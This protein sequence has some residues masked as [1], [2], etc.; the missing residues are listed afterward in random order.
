M[1]WE[2]WHKIKTLFKKS[3]AEKKKSLKIKTPPK[4]LLSLAIR[5]IQ[6]NIT[7]RLHLTPVRMAKINR[8]PDNKYQRN[9]GQGEPS[10][11]PNGVETGTAT[12]EIS[13]ASFQKTR[14]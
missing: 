2:N 9:L 3:F 14:H 13:V 1:A 12:L 8:T 4:C 11:T 7:S 5:E 6:A 10:F